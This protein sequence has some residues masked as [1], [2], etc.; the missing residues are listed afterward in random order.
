M[1]REN[2]DG[3]ESWTRKGFFVLEAIRELRDAVRDNDR[4]LTR[5]EQRSAIQSAVIGIIT[6]SLGV[7]LPYVLK[8]FFHS[9]P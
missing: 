5:L 8:Y 1:T 7:A 3:S 6:G 2:D 4:R 9:S